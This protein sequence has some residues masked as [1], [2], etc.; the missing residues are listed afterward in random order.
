MDR[1]TLGTQ[2]PPWRGLKLHLQ[3]ST[4][5]K[6]SPPF[7]CNKKDKET[8]QYNIPFTVDLLLFQ[9]IIVSTSADAK[10]TS[11]SLSVMSI[12]MI[13]SVDA[14]LS[15]QLCGGAYVSVCIYVAQKIVQV[16]KDFL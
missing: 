11:C 2:G 16:E 14:H 10:N 15:I 7:H 13:F 9:T 5:D 12:Y 6:E 8:T 3:D 4:T 1:P